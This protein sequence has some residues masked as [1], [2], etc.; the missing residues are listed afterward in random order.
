M[1]LHLLEALERLDM[2]NAYS[3]GEFSQITG[4]SVKT[5]RFYHE[6]G[7][8][9][10]TSVDESTGYRSY[11]AG[12]IDKARVIMQLR[13][14]EFS[15]EDIA[16]VLGQFDDEADILNQLERQK[17]FLQQRIR[18][19]RDIVHS[20]GDIITKEKAARKLLEESAM[21][22][23]EKKIEPMLVAGYRMKG[24]YDESGTGFGRLGKAVGRYIC[25]PALCLYYDGE[26]REEEA[27]FE[28]C[29]PVRKAVE[30]EGVSVRELPGARC[31]TLVHRGPYEQLGRSYAKIMKEGGESKPNIVLP[32]RE[33]YLKGPGMIFKGN[34]ENYL[35]EIQLPLA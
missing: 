8:L 19:D 32:T 4:L 33:V 9:V 14:M 1:T 10:P 18:E 30:A 24:K 25:G 28:P 7:I 13:Q 26:Y 29:F 3:I 20:L 21:T 12:K 5:L 16:A 2:K 34:P 22:V 17:Q 35:T 27:N 6:K 31:L 15:I 23:V 11:D